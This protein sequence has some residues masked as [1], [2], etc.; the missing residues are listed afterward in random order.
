MTIVISV[1]AV[2]LMS[3]TTRVD[4]GDVVLD[5]QT[6]SK[7]VLVSGT[8]SVNG[9]K[10]YLQFLEVNNDH[11]CF[12]TLLKPFERGCVSKF[13]HVTNIEASITPYLD[14]MQFRHNKQMLDQFRF[15]CKK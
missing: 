8:T 2:Q 7:Y 10:Q 3:N 12:N 5:K 4:F 14:V 1:N 13:T 9:K 11:H 6:G 15:Y